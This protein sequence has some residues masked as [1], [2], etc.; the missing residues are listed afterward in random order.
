MANG[1]RRLALFGP[2]ALVAVFELGHPI[3]I[4]PIYPAVIHHLP[5]WLHFGI[6]TL[7]RRR[8]SGS[9]SRTSI[10]DHGTLSTEPSLLLSQELKPSLVPRQ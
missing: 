6:F 2:P 4:P 8:R 1:L 9:R 7:I 3:P 10:V 5:W